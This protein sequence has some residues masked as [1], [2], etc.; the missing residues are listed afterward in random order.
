MEL[1]KDNNWFI[2]CAVSMD[3]K[4]A[5]QGEQTNISNEQD[6]K[7]V[8]GMRTKLAAIVVG[9][10]TIIID[11]PSLKTKGEYLEEEPNHPVR[12][13]MDRS[14]RCP[15]DAKV[16]QNLG[17]I[18]TVWV[19][20]SERQIAEVEKIWDDSIPVLIEKISNYLENIGRRGSV[21]IEGGA[22]VINEFIDSG[23]IT[24][25]RIF[26]STQVIPIGVDLFPEKLTRKLNLVEVNK[27][28]DG[29]EE[30]YTIA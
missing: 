19:T 24:Q 13:V 6:W 25:M 9:A 4:L 5:A 12:I 15:V 27:L 10:N 2:N 23:V 1:L 29:I 26:R 18:P 3:N 30:F 14:G 22:K 20:R 21:M 17:E 8:H 16:F 28:G 11:N 7:V